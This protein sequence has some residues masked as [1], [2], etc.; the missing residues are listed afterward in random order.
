MEDLG[1]M[2]RGSHERQGLARALERGAS[3]Y[4]SEAAHGETGGQNLWDFSKKRFVGEIYANV[5]EREAALM[6]LPF[7]LALLGLLFR[8]IVVWIPVSFFLTSLPLDW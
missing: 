2:E 6:R 3:Q 5:Y 1:G 8:R 7:A 4:E